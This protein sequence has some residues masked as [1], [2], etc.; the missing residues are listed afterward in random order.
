MYLNKSNKGIGWY[1]YV[2]KN[3][4]NED[5]E[6]APTINFVFK[7]GTKEPEMKKVDWDLFF[8]DKEGNKRLV[9]PYVDEW[10]D[11]QRTICFRILGETIERK[12]Q[13]T[14]PFYGEEETEPV[15]DVVIES[16]ELPF[17]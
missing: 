2:N 6:N 16:S 1:S 14:L 7:K 15:Q 4:R 10:G 11:G 12:Q 9:L 8:I 13:S 3:Q 17:Y 5:I